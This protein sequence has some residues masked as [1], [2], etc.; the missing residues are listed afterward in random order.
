MRDRIPQQV[1]RLVGIV[2]DCRLQMLPLGVPVAERV[3]VSGE[4][5]VRAGRRRIDREGFVVVIVGLIGVL[6]E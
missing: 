5:E 2:L 1:A 3:G 4:Q 6:R